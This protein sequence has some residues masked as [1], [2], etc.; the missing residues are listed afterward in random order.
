MTDNIAGYFIQLN[1]PDPEFIVTWNPLSLSALRSGFLTI[2][3]ENACHTGETAAIPRRASAG[4]RDF[5]SS[6]CQSG[7]LVE[8]P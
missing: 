5:H 8:I 2:L 1:L 3:P 4:H 6:R 7:C